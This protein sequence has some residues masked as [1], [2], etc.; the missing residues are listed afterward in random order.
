MISEEFFQN[1]R[2]LQDFVNIIVP[3]RS[4]YCPLEVIL[5]SFGG[6]ITVFWRSYF[7]PLEAVS[8]GGNAAGWY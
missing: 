5:L 4:Y 7:C 6:H 1:S 3:R 8:G 2:F